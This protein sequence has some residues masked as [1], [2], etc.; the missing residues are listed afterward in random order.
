MKRV[1][2]L[3]Q[4]NLKTKIHSTRG[5]PCVLWI[6]VFMCWL[7]TLSKVLPID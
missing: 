3:Y 6:L 4:L 5:I 2:V 7:L 1:Y